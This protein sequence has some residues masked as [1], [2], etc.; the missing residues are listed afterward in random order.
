[1]LKYKCP[2]SLYNLFTIS[3]RNNENLLL[4]CPKQALFVSSRLKIWN[5]CVKLIIK[6]EKIS[7]ITIGSFKCKVK[8]HYLMF[9]MHMMKLNGMLMIIL[10]LTPSQKL[11]TLLAEF[12]T[13]KKFKQ[14]HFQTIKYIF[15]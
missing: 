11:P 13:I 1:M 8:N 6:G 12:L 2:S 3:S 7:D 14:Q 15:I 10:I 9:N 4:E 5:S